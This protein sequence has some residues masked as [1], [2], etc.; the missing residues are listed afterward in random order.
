MT[1]IQAIPA[2]LSKYA[3][4]TGRAARPEFWW[5]VLFV[6]LVNIVTVFIDHYFIA[7]EL[8]IEVFTEETPQPLSM[9][10]SLGLLL[11]GL[12]VSARRLH[13]INRSGWWMLIILIPIIGGLVLLWW[14][15]KEGD[16]GENEFGPPPEV[17]VG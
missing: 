14:C 17:G 11:P 16:E 12:A 7:P 6:F 5:W 15:L 1:F 13:D 10:V 3:T 4:F 8:G 2:V 9:V